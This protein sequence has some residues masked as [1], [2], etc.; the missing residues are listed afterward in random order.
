MSSYSIRLK[1]LN[2]ASGTISSQILAKLLHD[3]EQAA[4][5][6]VRLLLDGASV[7]NG[8]PPSWLEQSTNFLI[9]GIGKGST[10]VSLDAPCLGDTAEELLKQTD[11]WRDVPN[12][13][14]TSLSV[15][16]L[17]VLDAASGK[18][19]SD[20]LDRGVL[21]SLASFGWIT[22]VA[23][24]VEIIAKNDKSSKPFI[25]N[26]DTFG[27]VQL[28][29]SRTPAPQ[30]MIV[31][32]KL[33]EIGHRSGQFKLELSDGNN[34]RG[35]IHPEFLDS[36]HLRDLWGR[37]VSAK[38]LVHFKPSGSARFLEAEIL[39]PMDK[40]EEVFEKMPVA[41]QLEAD[42]PG[43][44]KAARGKVHIS[45]IWN[46]WPGEESIEELLAKL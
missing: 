24:S 22:D 38:G 7:K 5:R 31:S 18:T 11:L 32:G 3:L 44:V 43:L 19:D 21:D 25:F 2:S 29:R 12:P 40:G 34:L 27:S 6:S 37:N 41:V 14:D 17:C 39:K 42:F 1:G 20:R 28:L 4:Q 13:D 9:T 10:I 45:E 15:L 23:K 8:P 36:E 30:A 33:E 35:R 46:M 16:S 26:K